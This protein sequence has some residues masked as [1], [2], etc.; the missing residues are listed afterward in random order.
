MS[1]INTI[2]K[3]RERTTKVVKVFKDVKIYRYER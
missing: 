1:I 2:I 3:L